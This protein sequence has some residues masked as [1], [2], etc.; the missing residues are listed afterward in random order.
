MPDP[1]PVPVAVRDLLKGRLALVTGAG[2]GIGA[3]L[4]RGLAAHGAEVIAAGP[5]GAGLDRTVAAIAEA[6]GRA[7]AKTVDVSVAESCRALAE[8][9]GR[10]A[11]EVAILVNNAGVIHYAT[12]DDPGVEAAWR[13][14][15]EVNLS[16]PFNMARAFLGPLKATRGAIVNIASIAGF[17]YT[18]NTA[19][20]SAS[21]GGVR[22]LTVALARELGPHGV[23]VN[24]VAPGSINT[25]MSP[26]S[27]DPERRAAL[28]RRVALGRIGQ[29]EDMVG[30]V[31]F[32]AS[33]MAAYVTGTT[34][35]ADG[36]YLTG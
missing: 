26:S 15:I 23:R 18:N 30:P 31:V 8:E 28:E 2:S 7:W 35:V 29:P 10:D 1:N 32:L 14:T 24:A 21:K 34:L 33:H 13:S 20:Y 11:G 6:G 12:L 17:I 19:G 16:G 3:A 25:P 36:G 27:S 4:A 5:P 9:V 22:M